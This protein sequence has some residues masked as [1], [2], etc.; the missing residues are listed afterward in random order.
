[1]GLSR[2]K[3][4][5]SW[6]T[7]WPYTI[8]GHVTGG[9]MDLIHKRSEYIRP[10][11]GIRH[12]SYIAHSGTASGA[13]VHNAHPD[14]RNPAY[15]INH[16]A[17]ALD[18]GK[19]FSTH[20]SLGFSENR[21]PGRSVCCRQG[22]ARAWRKSPLSTRRGC[23]ATVQWFVCHPSENKRPHTTAHA[24]LKTLTDKRMQKPYG[25]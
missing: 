11:K 17:W 15:A 24:V 20:R 23:R 8:P 16:S 2:M 12:Q 25:L 18:S 22:R 19:V 7:S 3:S 13:P 21:I 9:V 5:G 4:D 6:L 14:W 1:M 10:N